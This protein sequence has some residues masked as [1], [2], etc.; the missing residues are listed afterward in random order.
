MTQDLRADR[1]YGHAQYTSLYDLELGDFSADL[2]FY[3]KHLPAPPC[4][5]LELGC[6]TG[7]VSRPLAADGHRLIGIDLS[8]SMLAG[9]KPAPSAAAPHYACMDMTA[10][11]FRAT[12]AAIIAPYNTLNLLSA[13]ADLRTCLTQAH[14]LLAETGILLVQLYLP[15]K[16]LLALEGKKRF[17]FQIFDCPDGSKIIKE[18]LKST[19]PHSG[20]VEITERYRL[21]FRKEHA[22]EDREYTYQILACKFKQWLEIFSAL[23]FFPT[24]AYGD[25]N[26]APFVA[27]EHSTLLLA[28]GKASGPAK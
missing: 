27:D 19:V 28:L 22:N 18:I 2:A 26:F 8:F 3:R 21:R 5:I 24:A 9:A 1:I 10:L 12:F 6:G 23:G 11:A 25:Y 15:D 7:R 17:Q 14:R 20:L 13:P 16:E 4:A